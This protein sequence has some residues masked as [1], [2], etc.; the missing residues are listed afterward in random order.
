MEPTADE[1]NQI[2]TLQ[3]AYDWAGV[4]EDVRESLKEALGEPSKIRDIIFVARAVWDTI[5]GR[6]KGS[7]PPD[8]DGNRDPRDLTPVDVFRLEIFRR[9]CFRRVGAQ[10]DT[11]GS[12]GPAVPAVT[13]ATPASITGQPS[14][15]KLKMSAVV[16]QTLDAEVIA[17]GTDAINKMYEAYRAKYGDVPSPETEPTG[18]Q[19]AAVHQ[20]VASGAT[21]YIDFAVYGPHGLR[22]LRKLTFEPIYSPQLHGRVATGQRSSDVSGR[23]F[24]SWRRSQRMD[25]YA[26]HIRQ[27]PAR[28]GRICWDLVYTADVHMRS[29]QFERIRWKL[30]THTHPE[31]GY[32]DANPWNAVLAQATREDAFWSREVITPATLRLAQAKSIPAALQEADKPRFPQ[33]SEAEPGTSS[34]GRSRNQTT[35]Q[36]TTGRCTRTTAKGSSS[37]KTGTKVAAESRTSHHVCA[38]S[39]WAPTKGPAATR[40]S[41]ACRGVDRRR[42]PI[43]PDDHPQQ[44]QVKE[45]DRGREASH[46]A[47]P[48]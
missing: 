16:D 21:P 44:A 14:G 39:A 25:A 2:D 34:G 19:R 32:T 11:P 22:L 43:H 4:P 15:R 6:I 40:P 48:R 42:R 24:S 8:A 23:P 37:A 28:F 7:K 38:I 35:N 18:D 3:A 31:H 27:L 13:A 10:P 36:S 29:E 17:L 9:V 33:E 30:H 41:E 1:L 5:V 47:D 46:A 45:V 12:F 20:L 26:E